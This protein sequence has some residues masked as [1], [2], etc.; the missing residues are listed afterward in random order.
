MSK[1]MS[2]HARMA[3]IKSEL[4]KCKIPKSGHNKFAGFKYHELQDFMPFINELN[5]K[6]GINTVP[7][8]LEKQGICILKVINSDNADDNYEIIIPFVHAEMLGKGGA[9]SNV[10]AIQRMGST[11][12]Y[13]RRYLYMSAYDIVESDSVDVAEPTKPQ[14]PKAPQTQAP[15]SPAQPSPASKPRVNFTKAVDLI[16]SGKKTVAEIV[17]VSTCTLEEIA[18]LNEVEEVVKNQKSK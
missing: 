17:S 13:N 4:S 2:V 8:F 10:D 15:K 3:L 5:A 12:T 18:G 14:A 16:K 1:I 9:K 6:H 11:I 7:K